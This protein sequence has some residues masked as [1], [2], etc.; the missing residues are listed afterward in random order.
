M[1]KAKGPTRLRASTPRTTPIT[2]TR[3]TRTT[4]MPGRRLRHTKTV[5]ARPLELLLG[6]ECQQ[7]EGEVPNDEVMASLKGDQKEF[8]DQKRELEATLADND[9]NSPK[10]DVQWRQ[11]P[12]TEAGPGRAAAPAE[13]HLNLRRGQGQEPRQ[14]QEG[15][16]DDRRGQLGKQVRQ[17]GQEFLQRARKRSKRISSM[18]KRLPHGGRRRVFHHFRADQAGRRGQRHSAASE[19]LVDTGATATAGGQEAVN[20]LCA[21]VAA[22]R[23]DTCDP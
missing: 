13:A 10:L 21:A 5:G 18:G 20:R 9:Q 7:E 8:E 15:R 3:P 19:G 12:G 2:R 23:P 22:A 14:G 16:E 11:R 1:L 6:T 17:E 4:R